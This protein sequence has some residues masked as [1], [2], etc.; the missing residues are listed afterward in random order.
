M[1][2]QAGREAVPRHRPARRT[3]DIIRDLVR[4]LRL[5]AAFDAGGGVRRC[6]VCHNFLDRLLDA[7]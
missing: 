1:P 7:K 4:A 5:N 6:F 3:A 2:Y